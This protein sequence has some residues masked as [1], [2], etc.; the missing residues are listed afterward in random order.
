MIGLILGT[1]EGKKILSLLNEFTDDLFLSTAS[2]YGGELLKDYKYKLLNTTPLDKEKLKEAIIENNIKLFIDASHPYALEITKNLQEA[3]EETNIDYVRYQRPSIIEKY[4]DNN[5]VIIVEN[6]EDLKN[7]IE[8]LQGTI[9]NT[10]GS[11]NLK[12]ILDIN[13]DNRIIHRVLPSVKVLQECFDLGVKVEDLIA[14]KGPVS[15]EM[16]IAFIKEYNG[17]AMIMKDSGVQGGTEEKLKACINSDIYAFVI[18][19]KENQYK[20]VYYNE[21]DLVQYIYNYTVIND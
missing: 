8:E 19:R 2:N 9:L 15:Y 14:I 12:K 18:D 20:N 4:M 1:S 7:H 21:K 6:Y 3:C 16:N 13:A 5:K 10:S 11:R 17:K